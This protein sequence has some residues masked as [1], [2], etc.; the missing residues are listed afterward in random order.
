[1]QSESLEQTS[2]L[3]SDVSPPEEDDPSKEVRPPQLAINNEQSMRVA[4]NVAGTFAQFRFNCADST[5]LPV[6]V[7]PTP[8]QAFL[9]S[10]VRSL[11]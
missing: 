6:Y 2:R 5:E 4:L 7:A 11:Q 1:M 3:E 10:R 8:S 9:C